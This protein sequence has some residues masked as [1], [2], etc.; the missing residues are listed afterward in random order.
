VTSG[1]ESA[2]RG[3]GG[4]AL[5]RDGA[6]LVESAP[7]NLS[8]L[9]QGV[10]GAT[11]RG[12][13]RT[14]ITGLAYHTRDVAD[15]TLFFCVPGLKFDGHT[16]AG[17]A[18]EAGAGALVCER[19]T[20]LPVTQVIAPSVRRAMALMGSRW[21]GDPSEKLSVVGVTGTNG[22]TTTAHLVAGLFAAA[23]QPAGLLGTVVNR[24][25]GV[26]HGVKLTTA[27]SLD[28]QRMFAEMVEAGDKACA[29][30][31]SSHALAQ[32][33]AIGIDF[34]AVLF[35][36]LTRDHLD[37]H[38]DLED[39][40]RAKRRLFL[41]DEQRQGRAKAVVN[42][43]DEFGARLAG[44]CA[45]PYGDDLW[46][47]AVEDGGVASGAA[48]VAR[49]L[50]LHADGSAFS[51]VCPRLHVDE[52]VAL[53][54]AARFNVENAVAAA[55]AGLALG[56]PPAAV[57][58]ALAASEGVPGRF[59]AV[60]AGQ[61]FSVVVD[62]SHTPDSLENAL[63]AARAVTAGRVLVV[64][65]CGGDRDRGKRPLMGEIGA[66]LADRAVITSDNPRTEDPDAIIAEI[67]A[68]VPGGLRG[69]VV[70]EPDRRAAIRRALSEAGDADTVVIAGK[71]HEQGQLIGDRKIPFDD[72]AVAEEEISALRGDR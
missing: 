54:L 61:P 3:E 9:V 72:R 4:P 58:R 53:R 56:L 43:G 66:R 11:V 29:F 22:K 14:E 23:G 33:R 13:P 40:F 37:Y 59:Q 32:D 31:V 47:C 10:S 30:E 7:M 62:Y 51:L 71:G 8:E 35:S 49:D 42:I 27:E 17:T 44:E 1:G 69:R 25:G 20:G 50:E 55:T 2:G 24:I 65:G 15:G 5:I 57:V 41:P 16:F 68:G 6:G 39:Y 67:A 38:T 19:D 36:N 18:V 52:R 63:S 34:D 70:V 46:T 60:R 48:V 45:A 28:L 26:D 64:F 12:D 21:Y